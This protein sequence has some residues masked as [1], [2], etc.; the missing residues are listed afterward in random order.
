MKKLFL[1]LIASMAFLSGCS[2]AEEDL[3]LSEPIE[4]SNI[5]TSCEKINLKNNSISYCI[6][7][8][9]L[10]QASFKEPWVVYFFHGFEGEA[11][12]LFAGSLKNAIEKVEAQFGDRSPVFVGLSLGSRGL[13]QGTN[14]Y[15]IN[16][17]VFPQIEKKLEL[18]GKV[19]RDLIG[20][21]MG[22]HNA[23][24]V[25]TYNSNFGESIRNVKLL[26][27]A[28]VGFNPHEKDELKKYVDRHPDM[29]MGFFEKVMA[30]F[31]V[32][33][34]SAQAWNAAS[35]FTHLNE[36]SY[37][38]LNNLFISVGERDSLGF[39]EGAKLFHQ[40]LVSKN[41]KSTFSSVGGAHCSFDQNK[42]ID[43]F[44]N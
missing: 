33:Y 40:K 25:A 11:N 2:N 44:L 17:L 43:S 39:D 23:L 37:K 16:A 35:P 18:K 38:S 12:D 24:Q 30:F 6:E 21:S 15:E 32:K 7:K 10:A 34:P 31:M 28:L 19:K 8:K 14:S 20:M 29:D 3:I 4:S 41:I 5:D 13:V 1:L 22:A 27:P 9:E 26:C 36:N 42:L